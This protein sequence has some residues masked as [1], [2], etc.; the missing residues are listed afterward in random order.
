M[1]VVITFSVDK[2]FGLI[3]I[4]KKKLEEDRRV[5][6]KKES[7]STVIETANQ[8]FVLW[9]FIRATFHFRHKKVKQ[10][11]YRPGQALRVP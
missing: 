2:H 10:F 7:L 6:W 4:Y 9:S 1:L 3:D 8:R 11:H 5:G